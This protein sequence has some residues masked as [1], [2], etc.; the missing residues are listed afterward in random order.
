MWL[1]RCRSVCHG[2]CIPLAH[3]G[4][5]DKK[6]KVGDLG[7]LVPQMRTGFIILKIW[8]IN[9]THHTIAALKTIGD[10]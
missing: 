1:K 2:S 3:D 7:A 5:F 4:S 8:W 9:T 6:I 10:I